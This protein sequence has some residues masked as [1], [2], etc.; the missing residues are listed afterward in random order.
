MRGKREAEHRVIAVGVLLG[1]SASTRGCDRW[2]A[3]ATG[4]QIAPRLGHVTSQPVCR[5]PQ[6]LRTVGVSASAGLHLEVLTH[7]HRLRKDLDRF[8]Y[9]LLYISASAPC[10]LSQHRVDIAR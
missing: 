9:Q 7:L 4:K 1:T 2:T 6:P 10:P 3:V 5:A 8:S